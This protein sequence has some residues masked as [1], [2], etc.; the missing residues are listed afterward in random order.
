MARAYWR[1]RVNDH[2]AELLSYAECRQRHGWR[3]ADR[4]SN[5]C[6]RIPTRPVRNLRSRWVVGDREWSGTRPPSR[7]Q[8][9]FQTRMTGSRTG[10]CRTRRLKATLSCL[11][12]GGIAGGKAA[13]GIRVLT[14]LQVVWAAA[15][16]RSPAPPSQ[17]IR[18]HYRST[19]GRLE[20]R[21]PPRALD[22][23]ATLPAGRSPARSCR[24]RIHRSGR[25]DRGLNRQRAAQGRRLA[26][27]G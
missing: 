26:A 19:C 7:P 17:P 3:T 22:Q 4:V 13:L 20:T 25:T 18:S 6:S 1:Y 14:N 23:G 11:S 21:R 24:R 12:R 9:G 15:E 8:S 27:G 5:C 2:T 10:T 16:R